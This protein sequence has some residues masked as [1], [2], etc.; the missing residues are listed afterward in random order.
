RTPGSAG[1]LVTNTT[2]SFQATLT[3]GGAAAPGITI[4]F[5]VMGPNART[6]SA[7]TDSAGKA[8]FSYAGT[9]NGTDTIQASAT[10]NGFPVVSNTSTVG[11]VSP[12]QGVST[13]TVFGRFFVVGSPGAV[14]FSI[15]SDDGFI[16]GIGNG[17]TKA[18]GNPMTNAPSSTQFSNLPVMGAF[19]TATAPLTS[20]VTVTFPAAG[21]YPYELDYSDGR[22]DAL[23][24]TMSTKD[25]NNVTKPIPPTGTLTI[26]PNTFSIQNVGVPVT[27]NV[28]A[29]DAS[30]QA[31]PL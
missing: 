27:V 6:G 4:Q 26:T 31:V 23:V 28:N 18:P 17:A 3:N 2:Q 15:L 14:T 22:G 8:S 13:T 30:G 10:V 20:L 1:P 19:N 25:V 21:T 11:W 24:I 12:V 16:L 5:T 9:T 7:T 29:S